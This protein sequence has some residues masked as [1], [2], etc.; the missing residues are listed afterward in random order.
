MSLLAV[1]EEMKGEIWILFDR[2]LLLYTLAERD[3][4]EGR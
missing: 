1:G 4:K 2:V 3:G